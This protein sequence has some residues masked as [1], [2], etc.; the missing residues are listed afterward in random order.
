MT[1]KTKQEVAEEILRLKA[2][3]PRGLFKNDTAKKIELAVEALK[4]GLDES[5]EEFGDLSESE[6]DVAREALRWR[7]GES[8]AR[9]SEG[10][11]ELVV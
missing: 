4:D 2:L 3:K 1:P 11:G 5:A 9:P 7:A 6:Q 8:K 10:W